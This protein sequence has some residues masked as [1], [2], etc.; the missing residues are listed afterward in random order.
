MFFVLQDSEQP[1]GR[2]GGPIFDY[3]GPYLNTVRLEG[4]NKCVCTLISKAVW[5]L[6]ILWT[7]I[8]NLDSARPQVLD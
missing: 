1:Q 4:T 5:Q 7:E 2:D 3:L 8:Y 6:E